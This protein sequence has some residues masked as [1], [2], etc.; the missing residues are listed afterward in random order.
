MAT[1]PP[2]KLRLL[3][4]LYKTPYSST[5]YELILTVIYKNRIF[6]KKKPIWESKYSSLK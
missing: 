2:H 4:V 6:K 3:V 1:Y 5:S